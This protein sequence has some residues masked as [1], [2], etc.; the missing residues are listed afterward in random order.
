MKKLLILAVLLS[1]SLLHAG[2]VKTNAVA[3]A[4]DIIKEWEQCQ[5]DCADETSGVRETDHEKVKHAI[6]ELKNKC[7]QRCE[8]V[9]TSQLEALQDNTVFA[10]VNKK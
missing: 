1:G 8:S 9:M 5:V 6:E 3:K 2:N 7:I 10:I 4:R